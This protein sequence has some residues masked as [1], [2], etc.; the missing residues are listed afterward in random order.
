[1]DVLL[2]LTLLLFSLYVIGRNQLRIWELE[3]V[4]R[5]LQ[6]EVEA[7]SLTPTFNTDGDK[8]SLRPE[9]DPVAKEDDYFE[10][11]P[12]VGDAFVE[13]V[14][15]RLAENGNEPMVVRELLIEFARYHGVNNLERGILKDPPSHHTYH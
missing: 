4:A 15:F 1:M 13:W 5:R 3:A 12:H 10:R 2:S 8:V 7:V 14:K 11:F 9:A 6:D